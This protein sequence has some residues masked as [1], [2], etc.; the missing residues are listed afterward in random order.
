MHRNRI[1]QSVILGLTTFVAAFAW[2]GLKGV[3]FENG[4]W[5]WPSSGFLILLIF[6]GLG[7]L[8]TKSKAI[9]FISLSI[10]LIC[11]FFSFGFKLEYLAV[12]LIALLL[13][14]FGSC[15]AINEKEIR[16][17]I[18]V[19]RILKRGLPTVLTGLCLII[20]AAYYFSPLALYGQNKIEMP[21]PLF[22]IIIGPV[23]GM[24]DEFKDDF[25]QT[26]NQEINRHSQSYKQYFSLGLTAGFF[27]ALRTVAVVF[28]WLVI[29]LT[30]LIFKILVS[31]G[32]IKIQEKAVLKEVIEI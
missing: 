10:I 5:I 12:I 29:L 11:F 2:I 22:D 17:K 24:N 28:S 14:V 16:I 26:I 30:S 4:N 27:F 19:R 1:T 20:A 15:M 18:E 21:R 13:F 23:T 7:W 25:Y 9:L 8:I 32:A 6:L 3:L 31:L